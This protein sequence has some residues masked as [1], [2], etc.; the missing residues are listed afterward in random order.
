ML[1]Q[2]QISKIF[3][4]WAWKTLEAINRPSL[5]DTLHSNW[6][7]VKKD[8]TKQANLQIL[9]NVKLRYKW[10]Q[11][12]FLMHSLSIFMIW[13]TKLMK[14]TTFNQTG[15]FRSDTANYPVLRLIWRSLILILRTSHQGIKYFFPALPWC[16]HGRE[17]E[18]KVWKEKWMWG[19]EW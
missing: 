18:V 9:R 1:V 11:W 7:V 6:S 10:K 15:M 14:Q 17:R 3:C 8:N 5:T 4:S 12:H 19:K 16:T 13:M 2:S